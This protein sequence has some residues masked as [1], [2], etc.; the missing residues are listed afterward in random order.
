[1]ASPKKSKLPTQPKRLD[2]PQKISELPDSIVSPVEYIVDEK[3]YKPAESAQKYPH[4]KTPEYLY[5]IIASRGDYVKLQEEVTSHLNDGWSLAGGLSV[6]VQ[7]D[8]YSA[9]TLFT[10]AVFKTK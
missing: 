3:E 5:K 9:L 1:M 8:H 10:Q 2:G 7:S 4:I 6:A